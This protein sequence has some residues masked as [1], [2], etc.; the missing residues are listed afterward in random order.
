MMISEPSHEITVLLGSNSTDAAVQMAIAS[1]WLGE[2]MSV[3]AASGVYPSPPF[4]GEGPE[5]LNRVVKGTYSGS[6]EKFEAMAKIQ[7][8]CQG[9]KRCSTI[10]TIDIDLISYDM[11]PVR[12]ADMTRGYFLQGLKELG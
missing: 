8:R 7:E 9:R 2:H 12:P 1:G 10:V 5:Y 6:I 4:G 3:T 11:V